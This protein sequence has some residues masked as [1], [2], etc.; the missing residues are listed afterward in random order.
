M[1]DPKGRDALV[2]ENPETQSWERLPKETEKAFRAFIIYR[3]LAD[4]RLAPVAQQ[5]NCSVANVFRWADKYDWKERARQ[6]DIY[7]DRLAQQ[8]EI[9]DRAAVPALCCERAVQNRWRCNEI[10]NMASREGRLNWEA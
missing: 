5:L 1:A 4:H 8:A 3:G 10:A 6:W 7:N 2:L 9:K